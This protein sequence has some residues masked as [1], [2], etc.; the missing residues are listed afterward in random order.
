MLLQPARL[1]GLAIIAGFATVVALVNDFSFTPLTVTRKI[2]LIALIAP[3]VGIALDF[4]LKPGATGRVLLGVMAACAALWAFWPV[5]GQRGLMPALV[6]G[7]FIAFFIAW[8]VV[9]TLSLAGSPVRAGAAGLALGIGAGGLA[10]LGASA[11]YGQY[12]IAIGAAAGAFLLV[13]MLSGKKIAAGAT[14]TLPAA[15]ITGLLGAATML[16][17]QLRWYSLV[18]LA[19][20]PVAAK[21]PL[22]EKMPPWLQAIVASF[23]TLLVVAC[24]FALAYFSRGSAS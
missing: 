1:G 13:P 16:L 9:F 11:L 19:L 15:L 20:V 23:F 18:V 5:L 3:L 7:A 17:A 12:G 14:F 4:V 24:A 8:L 2:M 22:P 6:T 21:L 10:I